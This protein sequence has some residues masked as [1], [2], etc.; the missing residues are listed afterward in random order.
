[1]SEGQREGERKSHEGQRERGREKERERIPCR[2][3]TVGT[4]TEV[5]LE[6]MHEAALELTNHEIMI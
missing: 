3:C 6:L 1:M 5:G 2:N 4:E